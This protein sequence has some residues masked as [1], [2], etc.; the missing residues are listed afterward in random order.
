MG[1]GIEGFEDGE[2]CAQLRFVVLQYHLFIALGFGNGY[3]H[4][5]KDGLQVVNC[6]KLVLI[7]VGEDCFLPG[8][9]LASLALSL[10]RHH[11][12]FLACSKTDVSQVNEVVI[13]GDHM[14]NLRK[15]VTLSEASKSDI[16]I[17]ARSS[18]ANQGLVGYQKT[19]SAM[20]SD[21]W[22]YE[23]EAARC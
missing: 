14:S 5:W 15:S 20:L 13:T 11:K 6:P 1:M 22:Q 23:A 18:Q 2:L 16:R 7:E 17:W 8:Q 9:T 10:T 3:V 4:F 19:L 12:S 21:R